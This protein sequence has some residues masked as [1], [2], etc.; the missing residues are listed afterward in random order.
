MNN[1]EYGCEPEFSI[2]DEM[3]MIKDL[4]GSILY[5]QMEQAKKDDADH[6]ELTER[7]NRIGE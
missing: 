3:Q 4:Q 6:K 7:I 1:Y 2:A 5:K